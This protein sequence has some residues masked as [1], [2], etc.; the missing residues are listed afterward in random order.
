MAS[1]SHHDDRYTI[2][3]PESWMQGRT[4]YGGLS[5]AIA[6]TTAQRQ[7]DPLPPLRSA[8]IS[9]V[10]P[11]AGSLTVQTEVLRQG[12]SVT[13][14][15]ADVHGEKGLATR[16]V[17]GF[18]TARESMFDQV[19]MSPPP[20]LP[21]PDEAKPFFPGERGPAFTANYE[22]RLARGGHP[23]SSSNEHNHF[24]WV[25]HRDQ[26]AEGMTALLALADMPPPAMLPMFPQMAPISSMTWMLNFLA[27]TP[28]TDDGWWLL[29]SRAEH[30]RDGYSSQD[31]LVW[32]RA[33]QPVIAGRQSVALFL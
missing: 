13:F 5:A 31:M 20:D 4:L 15:N 11:C 8:Q 32:N 26:T 7:H 14:I 2:D 9:F 1:L 10:G 21:G 19:F 29:Q 6:L 24:L 17:F 30:A 28:R 33:G 3:V 23:V 18:G 25:R 12:R 27:D 22:S 16:A